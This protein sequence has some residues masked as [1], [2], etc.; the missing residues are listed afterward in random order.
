M[1]NVPSHTGRKTGSKNV[2]H[3]RTGMFVC[4]LH[5]LASGLSNGVLQGHYPSSSVY[6]KLAQQP[7]YVVTIAG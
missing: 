4:G 1:G 5:F 2:G 7:C 3:K 6:S